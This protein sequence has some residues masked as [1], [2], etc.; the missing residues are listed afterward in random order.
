MPHTLSAIRELPNHELYHLKLVHVES[1]VI[2]VAVLTQKALDLA[3]RFDNDRKDYRFNLSQ[4]LANDDGR[5]SEGSNFETSA[6]N[7]KLGLSDRKNRYL[8]ADLQVMDAKYNRGVK[9]HLDD[10]LGLVDYFHPKEKETYFRLGA[11]ARGSLKSGVGTYTSQAWISPVT[12]NVA[13]T[14]DLAVAWYLYQHVGLLPRNNIEH[15]P[16]AYKIYASQK[17]KLQ[18]QD[19][20]TGTESEEIKVDIEVLDDIMASNT[21]LI[22]NPPDIAPPNNLLKRKT[23]KMKSYGALGSAGSSWAKETDSEAYKQTFCAPVMIDF[24]GV[25]D[26]V[27]SVDQ[28][29]RE[30]WLQGQHTD[31]GGGAPPPIATQAASDPKFTALSNISLRWMVQECLENKTCITF[32][33]DAMGLYRSE[34]VLEYRPA[35]PDLSAY[36]AKIQQAASV[37]KRKAALAEAKYAERENRR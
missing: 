36:R 25:W 5:W 12:E 9:Y 35:Q 7:I 29:V 13:K 20:N 1:P 22:G 32:D 23:P 31:V 33:R 18:T 15:A 16:F 2:I 27:G 6:E 8:V 19:A 30:V 10:N 17:P 28:D 37:E 3:V 26:T 11:K 14:A 24:V 21:Q 34:R 4:F